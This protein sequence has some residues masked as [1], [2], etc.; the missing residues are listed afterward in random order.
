MKEKIGTAIF[1]I[2]T[3]AY[4]A[5]IIVVSWIAFKEFLVSRLGHLPFGPD[6][7]WNVIFF[8]FNALVIGL[9]AEILNFSTTHY[10]YD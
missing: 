10:Y 2:G 4:T 1:T 3:I 7:L 8:F 9:L 5:F 6:W